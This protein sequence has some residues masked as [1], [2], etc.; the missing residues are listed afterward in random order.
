MENGLFLKIIL[1]K[2]DIEWDYYEIVDCDHNHETIPK[3]SEEV[4][5]RNNKSLKFF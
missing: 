1:R 4:A 5:G 3:Q 2:S